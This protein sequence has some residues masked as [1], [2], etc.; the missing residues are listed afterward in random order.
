VS[1]QWL[2]FMLERLP[3]LQEQGWQIEIAADFP[4]RLAP[5]GEWYVQ[6][7]TD[8]GWFDVRLGMIVEGQPVN[9]LPAL[10]DYLQGLVGTGLSDCRRLGAYLL[11]RLQDQR[12]LPVPIERLQQVADTLVELF[13]HN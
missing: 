2:E 8:A 9:L 13:D 7:D 1:D 5:M 12:H 10:V 4:Y 3:Q 6:A 11:T